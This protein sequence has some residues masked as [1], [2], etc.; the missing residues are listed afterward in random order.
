MKTRKTKKY[1][2]RKRGGKRHYEGY[3]LSF[4]FFFTSEN[5]GVCIKNVS[6]PLKNVMRS[7]LVTLFSPGQSNANVRCGLRHLRY[8]AWEPR[9]HDTEQWFHSVQVLHSFPTRRTDGHDSEEQTSVS[10]SFPS[11]WPVMEHARFLKI[12]NLIKSLTKK[13]FKPFSI[14]SSTGSSTAGPKAPSTPLS[15]VDGRRLVSDWTCVCWA[16]LIA[17]YKSIIIAVQS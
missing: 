3:L 10:S 16:W 6:K 8:L 7:S 9:P 5:Q 15:S 1:L 13:I 11:H 17:A 14:T 12:S 4:S 2:W